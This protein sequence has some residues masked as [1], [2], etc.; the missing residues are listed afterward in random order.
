MFLRTSMV[1]YII[2]TFTGLAGL[3]H[4]ETGHEAEYFNRDLT[5]GRQGRSF[6]SKKTFR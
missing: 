3:I 1:T 6:L 4:V 2:T 5:R